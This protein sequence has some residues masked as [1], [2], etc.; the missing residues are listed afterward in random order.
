MMSNAAKNFNILTIS[1]NVL[2][3][4]FESFNK[5]NKFNKFNKINNVKKFNFN[6]IIFCI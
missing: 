5:I 6:K 1:L 4:Y 3:N 2:Y